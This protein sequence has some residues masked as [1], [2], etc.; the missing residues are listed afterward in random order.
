MTPPKPQHHTAQAVARLRQM[1]F[2]GE[3]AAG[4]DHLESELA[5]Q[6]GMSRTPVR[7]ALLTLQAQGLIE[8]RPRRGV[9]VRPISPTDMA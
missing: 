8:V 9:R 6:L 3:L 2:S 7:E 5:T 4:T 1:V